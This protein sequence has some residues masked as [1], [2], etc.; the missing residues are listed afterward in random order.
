MARI[1]VT[2]EVEDAAAWEAGYRTHGDLLASMGASASYFAA[3]DNNEVAIYAETDDLAG[4]MEAMESQTTADAMIADGVKRETV[5]IY[6]LD[7]EFH[8]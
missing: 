7:K 1:I 6:V 2:A 3:T 4:Y 5:K 8:Y